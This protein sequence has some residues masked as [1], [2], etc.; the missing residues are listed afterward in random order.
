[1]PSL[2]S[3]LPTG[4]QNSGAGPAAGVVPLGS[5]ADA[6]AAVVTL[7]P[8]QSSAPLLELRNHD[9][10]LIGYLVNSPEV[11]LYFSPPEMDALRRRAASPVP[12]KT[13][14]EIREI[15]RQRVEG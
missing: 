11:S 1:M 9:N 12:G 8:E 7:T 2:S 3:N 14:R 4:I 15:A 5:P 6:S 13:M 10:Q